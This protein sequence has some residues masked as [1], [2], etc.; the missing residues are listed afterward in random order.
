MTTG[1]KETFMAAAFALGTAHAVAQA[2]MDA[3][4]AGGIAHA[5]DSSPHDFDFLKGSWLM[6]NRTL[7]HRHVGS[8][9]WVEF[10]GRSEAR[11]LLGGVMNVDENI[12]PNWSG[13]TIRMFDL[14]THEWSIYW[15]SSRDGILQPPVVGHFKDGVGEFFGDD[16]DEGIPI[17]ARFRW[18]HEGS[19]SAHWEQAFSYDGGLNWETNWT[20]DFTR[21]TPDAASRRQP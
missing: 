1:F 10:P 14:K 9:E 18:R 7:K 19:A 2:P 20:I 21:A 17:K 3:E 16:M 5:S 15:V 4:T 12:F 8:T 6:R 11:L 13:S